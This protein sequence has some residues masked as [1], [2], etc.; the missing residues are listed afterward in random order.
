[1]YMYKVFS[2]FQELKDFDE[3]LAEE[4]LKEVGKGDWQKNLIMYYPSIEDYAEYELTDGWYAELDF[5]RDFNGAPNPL[6][7]INMTSL[8]ES[9]SN[10][11][12][13]SCYFLTRE[14]GVISSS[15]GW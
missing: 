8:G 13:T 7:H 10:N 14:E 15:H 9:L 6:N 11:W 4:L 1:M 3:K 2:E 5:E 12:D